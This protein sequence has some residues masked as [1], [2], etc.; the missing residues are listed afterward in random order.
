M[1][2]SGNQSASRGPHADQQ[3]FAPPAPGTQVMDDHTQPARVYGVDFSADRRRA[4]EKIWVAEAV[5]AEG[6]RVVDCRP[7]VEYLDV[8]RG[9]D[10]AIPALTAFLAELGGD[11]AVG[12]DVPFSLP[13]AVV[14]AE[15]WPALLRDL[16]GWADD[17]ADLARECEARADLGDDA[18]EVLRATEASLGAMCPYNRRLR[19]QT[20]YGLR[21]V[22][23]PLV[24]TDA[25]RAVPMQTPA[26]GRA[27]LL[28]VYPAG[29][30]ER[31]DAH[32]QR[33]K[34]DGEP[35]R[36]RRAANVDALAGAGTSMAE[37]VVERAVA[38][39]AG[40]ALDAVVAAVAVARHVRDPT[41]LRTDDA[42]RRLEGHVYV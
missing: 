37:G 16:P 31:L 8:D 41:A 11:A 29:T 6:S 4:G 3:R 22:L 12:M 34:G 9:R 35:E 13:E 38:D 18:A 25:A 28:E 26:D 21:D 23:R 36:G 2:P 5:L 14:A 1:N 10:A 40:D 39:E 33:Y 24:L 42:T 32:H 30:L 27:T 17:P 15:D 20:F 7:A 19:A